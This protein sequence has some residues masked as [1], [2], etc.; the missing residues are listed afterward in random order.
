MMSRENFLRSVWPMAVA[1][2]AVA[3]AL[4][5]RA[6]GAETPAMKKAPKSAQPSPLAAEGRQAGFR[7]NAIALC[8]ACEPCGPAPLSGVDCAAG[9][10]DD[11]GE[12]RWRDWRP[13][14]WQT[15]GHGEYIGPARLPHVSEYHLRVDDQLEM[16]YRLTR[17][18]TSEPYRLNVGDE[19][20]VESLIDG[21]LDRDLVI[22]PDGS[23]TLRLLGQMTAAQRTVAQLR[24]EI[25]QAY[26]K[27][28]REPA[29]SVTPLK[30][31]TKLEDIRAAVD[32]R[33]GQGGQLRRVRVTP[34][35]DVQLV[36]IGSVRAMG[37]TLSE[38]KAEVDARY[39]ELVDGIEVT[40]V[41]EARA[42]RYVYVV[43]EVRTPNRFTLEG[44][45]T[46][47]Q[48]IALAGGWINTGNLREIVVFRRADDWRLMA[49]RLDM[50]GALLGA[51]PCPADEIWLR[52]SDVVIVPKMPIAVLDDFIELIFTRGVYGVLPISYFYNLNTA[53]VL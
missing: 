37:L 16:I 20:R 27:Y 34:E 43:G 14:D 36:G 40:P 31:N 10:Q 13:I 48:A 21:K 33:A 42:P 7:G 38:L 35:G 11:C 50:R 28:Y 5:L 39:A 1:A 52:D 25:D 44:P 30:V 15:Y 19:I 51:K 32:S 26:M 41:L 4:G 3:A 23:I 12:A 22:Q 24:D 46:V 47:T 6:I 49:T 29:I 9:C 53:T 45:T 17:E 2:G 8:Q 18:Q